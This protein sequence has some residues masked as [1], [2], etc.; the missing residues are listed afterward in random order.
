M[1]MITKE[2]KLQYR[3]SFLGFLWSLL[4]PL[5]MMIVFT[6]IFSFVFRFDVK[7]FPIFLLCG[8]LPWNFHSISLSSSTT[9]IVSSGLIKKVYFP[10]EI[11]P[12]SIVIASFINFL[13]SLIVLFVFLIYYGYPFYRVIY[14]LPFVLL[15]Q[16]I[17]SLG[18]GFLVSSLNV[19]FRDIQHFISVLLLVWFYASPIIYP[20][21]KVIP[22]KYQFFYNLNPL[23]SVITL[24]R[25]VLY[26]NTFPELKLMAYAILVSSLF[27]VVG[28]GIFTRLSGRF[29]EEI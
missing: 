10:R 11:L 29:A 1:N 21:D 9:A 6:L 7:N 8:L 18:L 23:A 2:L 16:L 5:L 26:Y 4:S 3:N 27:L 25:Q 24:Y 13:L 17:F 22:E 28:Y 12:I 14:M 19:Y 15:I 20:A